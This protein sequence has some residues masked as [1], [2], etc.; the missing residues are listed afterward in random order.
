MD[1]DSSD[2]NE[3]APENSVLTAK[4]IKI[5]LS[6]TGPLPPP[7]PTHLHTDTSHTY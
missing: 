7:H 4:P 5:L 2:D 1:A 3:I 6:L